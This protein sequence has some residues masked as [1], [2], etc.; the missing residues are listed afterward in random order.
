MLEH[1]FLSKIFVKNIISLSY[2]FQLLKLSKTGEKFNTRNK[3]LGE[4]FSQNC[5]S[6]GN[7]FFINTALRLI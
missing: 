1:K 7:V 4:Y 6:A 2:F 5:R 3:L